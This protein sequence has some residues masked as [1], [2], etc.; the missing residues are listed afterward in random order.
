MTHLTIPDRNGRTG[1]GIARFTPICTSYGSEAEVSE[2]AV[3]TFERRGI[4]RCD[5]SS[6][7]RQ[8]WWPLPSG[9]D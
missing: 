1:T 2:P 8:W 6:W 5:S 9:P 7:S 4:E 3:K